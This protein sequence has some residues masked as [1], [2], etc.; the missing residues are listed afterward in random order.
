MSSFIQLGTG[1]T[2]AEDIQFITD[3]SLTKRNNL[4]IVDWDIKRLNQVSIDFITEV[5]THDYEFKGPLDPKDADDLAKLEG[6]K[7]PQVNSYVPENLHMV[8][9]C[10]DPPKKEKKVKDNLRKNAK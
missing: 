1:E 5:I 8:S 9:L 2:S 10:A 4:Y 7:L 3:R 6:L